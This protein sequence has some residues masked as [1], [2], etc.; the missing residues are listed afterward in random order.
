MSVELKAEE[1]TYKPELAQTIERYKA[2][3]EGGMADRPPIRIRYPIPG[4]SDE[5]WQQVAQDTEAHFDYWE[6]VNAHRRD[7]LD[8]E[9]SCAPVYLGPGLM[10][11]IMGCEMTFD[12]GTSWGTHELTDFSLMD[13]FR[14]A[15]NQI[16]TNRWFLLMKEQA[17]YFIRMGEGKFPVGVPLYTGPGDMMGGVR[18]ISEIY[19]DFYSAP[20]E[21]RELG[22][23]CMDVYLETIRRSMDIFP[24]IEGGYTDY[25]GYWYPGKTALVN[26]D[27]SSCLSPEMYREFMFDLDCRSIEAME[28]GGMHTHSLQARLIPEYLKIPGLKTLQ[29]VNDWPA[30]PPLEEVVPQMTLVQKNHNLILRKYTLEELEPYFRSGELK[31]EGLLIDTQCDSKE[32]AF[33]LLED[34]S[35]RF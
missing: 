1:M 2:F 21:L 17:E 23:I 24:S 30:G 35:N 25:Y 13:R 34:W 19:M 7:L 11:G 6:M 3:W 15:A 28:T 33:K 27:L 20:E 14:D 22:E 4:Q 16:E 8:D 26:D 9:I 5:E 18:G 29:I 31:P 12:K 32:E 10:E